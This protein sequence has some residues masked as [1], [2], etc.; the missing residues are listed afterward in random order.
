MFNRPVSYV[1]ITALNATSATV[2]A[3]QEVLEKSCSGRHTITITATGADVY[4]GDKNVS[5]SNGMPIAN[6]ESFTIPV[7]T[8]RFDQVYVVGGSVILTE[9]F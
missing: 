3:S 7:T 8:D 1:K 6:G 5:A 4:I 9:W 2:A